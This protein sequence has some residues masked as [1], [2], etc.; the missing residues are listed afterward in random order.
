MG[1]PISDS[2]YNKGEKFSFTI[3]YTS[4]TVVV[5]NSKS[6]LELVASVDGDQLKGF[7]YCYGTANGGEGD[8]TFQIRERECKLND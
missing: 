3:T 8:S 6:G 2:F 5:R 1:D 7:R 4:Q